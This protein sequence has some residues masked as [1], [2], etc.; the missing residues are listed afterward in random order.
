MNRGFSAEKPAMKEEKGAR[1]EQSRAI[2][3]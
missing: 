1:D 3:A 2:R